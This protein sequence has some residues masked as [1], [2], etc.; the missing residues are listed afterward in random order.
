MGIKDVK[1]TGDTPE[2]DLRQLEARIAQARVSRSARKDAE[3]R[4]RN[5]LARLELP[6]PTTIPR[7]DGNSGFVISND[8]DLANDEVFLSLRIFGEGP[9]WERVPRTY[10]MIAEVEV[11]AS[12]IPDTHESPEDA[13]LEIAAQ[14]EREAEYLKQA[15]EELRARVMRSSLYPKLATD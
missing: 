9:S 2:D 13:L 4:F 1:I 3:A 14:L 10:S 15:A 8:L 11:T 7:P 12:N 5:D 6:L